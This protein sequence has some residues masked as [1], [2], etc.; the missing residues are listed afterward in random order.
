MGEGFKADSD[1]IAGYGLLV[2]EVAGQMSVTS[3]HVSRDAAADGDF[4][5]IMALLKKPVDEYAEKTDTRL[6]DRCDRLLGAGEE[7]KRA[8]WLYSGAEESAYKDLSMTGLGPVEYIKDY[9]DPVSYK[10]PED[11]TEGLS[12]PDPEDADIRELLDEVGGAINGIDDA[13]EWIT[14]WS[15][16]SALVSPMSG[17][18]TRM[19]R[20]GEVLIQAGDAAEIIAT[21]LTEPLKKLDSHWNGGAAIAFDDYVHDIAKAISMEGPLNRIVG[22]VYKVVAE[23]IKKCAQWMVSVLKAAVDKIVEAAAS[24]WIPGAGWWRIIEAVRKAVDI[25]NAGKQMLEDLET[26]R[27]QVN[28]VVEAAQDPIGF[29]EGKVEE[30]LEPIREK[31]D[32]VNKGADVAGDVADLT[33]ADA[34]KDA[35]DEDYKIGAKPRRPGA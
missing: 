15:P 11:A 10:V 31:I 35:P 32:Q 29:V 8:A 5:G 6:S 13:V 3:A 2:D 9:P 22:D 19:E 17:N 23:E 1:H 20:A 12:A 26:V 34:W 16:V 28:T 27:D 7:L 33:D 24:Y 25:F 18:W 14:K 21:N 4:T 30:Q